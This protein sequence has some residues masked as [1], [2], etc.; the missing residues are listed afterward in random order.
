MSVQLEWNHVILNK[1]KSKNLPENRE[2]VKIYSDGSI[3]FPL[4]MRTNNLCLVRNK[5]T[6]HFLTFCH[7][8]SLLQSVMSTTESVKTSR[9]F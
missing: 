7:E 8:L 3:E 5:K 1:T 9:R 4:L 6:Y 2:S